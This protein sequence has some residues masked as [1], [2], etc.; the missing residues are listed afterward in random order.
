[1]RPI[2]MTL[3]DFL[4]A[5]DSG[6]DPKQL[7]KMLKSLPVEDRRAAGIR[8]QEAKANKPKV[9]QI[10]KKGWQPKGQ[11][12]WS[13]ERGPMLFGMIMYEG[14]LIIRH[15]NGTLLISGDNLR[16]KEL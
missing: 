8:F 11:L 5:V 2:A 16:F 1:M 4:S 7:S 13:L 3:S 15:N 14:E 6:T 10:E 12:L 9:E